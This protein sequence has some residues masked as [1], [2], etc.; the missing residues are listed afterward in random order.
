MRR[1]V[2]LVCTS[3]ILV[4]SIILFLSTGCG[5][6]AGVSPLEPDIPSGQTS[7]TSSV[8]TIALNHHIWGV[9]KIS[10]SDDHRSAD[11]IPVRAADLHLNV[12]NLIQNN[13][14]NDCLRISNVTPQP[15][16]QLT[17]DLTLIHPFP[18]LPEYTGFD[19][20]G[21]FISGGDYIFP[22][23]HRSI[24]W[25]DDTAQMLSRDGYTT[26]FNPTE[27]PINQP[28][29]MALRYIPGHYSPGGDL[30]ATLNPYIAYSKEFPRRMFEAGTQETLE[31]R[32]HVPDGP[33]EFGYAID[34]CWMPVDGEVTNPESDFPPDANCLEAFNI[35]VRVFQGLGPQYGTNAP[36][37]VDVHD[38]QSIETIESVHIEAP[39][40]FDG[41]AQLTSTVAGEDFVTFAGEITNE[42][43]APYGI[44]PL[45]VHAVD[46]ESD[47]NLGQIDAWQVASVGINE[48]WAR[49]WGGQS[50]DLAI[51]LVLDNLGRVLVLGAFYDT[52]D[53]D[54]GPGVDE[55]SAVGDRDVFLSMFDLVGN[56]LRT[57]TFG[58]EFYENAYAIVTGDTGDIYIVGEFLGLTDFD[59]GPG[60]EERTLQP[61]SEKDAFLL[62]LDSE[63]NF[64]RV[65]TWGGTSHTEAVAVM[66]DS[67]GSIYLTGLYQGTT[68]F[69][70]GPGVDRDTA[71]GTSDSYLSKFTSKGDYLWSR[72]WGGPGFG[73]ST[74]YDIAEGVDGRIMVVGAFVGTV[75]FDPSPS[76][77]ERVTN[78]REDAYL[79]WFDPEGNHQGVLTWGGVT[80]D[81]ARSIAVDPL[82]YS[83]IGGDFTSTVDFNPGTGI[84]ERY[85]RGARA[86]VSKFDPS[87]NFEWVWTADD[88][89][90]IRAGNVDLNPSWNPV[91][92]GGTQEAYA[93]AL[94]SDGPLLWISIWA[95]KYINGHGAS[96]LDIDAGGYIYVIG[97]FCCLEDF[98]PGP[99][100][101][102]HS[103]NGV[104]DAF[105]CML[106]PDGD[107]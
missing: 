81:Y 99:A 87:M 75:D 35:D 30:S 70:P 63:C 33:L 4:S 37:E 96:G 13:P 52:A 61:E 88:P 86:Y 10:I 102:F 92:A 24:A 15:S 69:D 107:W 3:V 26:L 2:F 16:N 80:H 74:G 50:D 67:I 25:T 34:A 14:C 60:V 11:V 84:E 90:M 58:G 59:P 73:L 8:S 9:W 56:H 49:T 95:D 23:S 98:N 97:H 21:I 38:H 41:V 79:T 5:K 101:E 77:D 85:S 62:I 46:T 94:D 29:P 1:E 44:Y 66:R 91:I 65:E 72:R 43:G 45:L 42:H 76:V 89:H 51:D 106:T 32:L 71:I 53:F 31:V 7:G 93:A 57:V 82:G 104:D 27:Y 17:A 103:S 19:V 28:G 78:G 54:P 55:H 105:L 20:R 68:D 39:D 12:L 36:I 22:G 83:Y 18:G 6:S 48:G 100:T 40:L 64:K 47:P